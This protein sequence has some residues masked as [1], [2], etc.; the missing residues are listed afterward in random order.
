MWAAMTGKMRLHAGLALALVGLLGCDRRDAASSS[1]SRRPAPE[2]EGALTWLNSPPLTLAELRGKVVLL[3]FFDYNCVNCLRTLP[4]LQEWERRYARQGL[5]IIGVHTPQYDFSTDPRNVIAAVRRLHLTQPILVD[6]NFRVS[7]AYT[8]RFWP[9][10]YLIDKEG[11]IGFD[12]VGEGDYGELE[13]RIQ[14]LLR[15]VN[16]AAE[17]PGPMRPLRGFD[18]PGAI[19]YPITPEMFLGRL[20]GRLANEA[21]ARTNGTMLVTL[22]AQLAENQVYAVGE[23]K[24]ESEYLRHTRDSEGLTDFVV[25]VYRATDANV[26]MKPEDV[27]WMKVFVKQDGQWLRKEIAGSDVAF[28]EQGC[29]YVRVDTPRMYNLVA[30]QPYGTHEL[31]LFPRTRGLSVYSFSFGT[32]EIPADVRKLQQARSPS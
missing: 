2:L 1:A 22:P 5:S 14:Q 15:E 17:F 28:D 32:C 30:G 20:R 4:Y 18:K 9:H 29:S 26:V 8:N 7:G 10:Q 24:I 16:P 31:R 11:R 27:Y 21:P 6:S 3:Y 25:A 23:W 13:S 19:C 12:H